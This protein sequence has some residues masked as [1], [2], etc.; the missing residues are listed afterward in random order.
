M[1]SDRTPGPDRTGPLADVPLVDHHCHGVVRRDLDTDDLVGLLT[2]SGRQVPGAPSVLDSRIGL[3]LRRWCP[4]ILDLPVHAPIEDYVA[5]RVEL[6]HREVTARMLRAC[7]ATTFCVDTGFVPEPLLSPDE[8]AATVG[9][10]AGEVVRLET[11]AE[12]AVL[13]GTDAAGFTDALRSL[14]WSR[15]AAAVATKSIA[16]YRV[17]LDLDPARPG[18]AEVVAAAGRWLRTLETDD[19][20][21]RCADPVLSRFL[22]W[23]AVERG[24]PI[25]V[26][27]GLGDAD[28]DL[29]RCDPL[30]L[31]PLLR[32]TGPAGVAVMLL[33]NYPFQRHAGYLAQVFPHVH[34][35]VGL[36]LHNVGAAAP[37]V[38][39]ELLELAPFGKVLYSSD[40]FGLPE[41]YL[42][43]AVAF[44]RSL[45]GL[46][47]DGVSAGEWTAA[48][49]DRIGA[50]LAHGNARRVY[51]LGPA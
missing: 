30:L 37:R 43:G 50:L 5:R 16:A 34:A 14:L 19:A 31:T 21:V 6:G 44:R 20:E 22:W 48:D 49:A 47:V 2:E 4:P 51:G 40:A 27:V 17:G 8:L 3:S 42:L 32:A 13:G 33:H 25:Q 12:E 38:L 11:L 10:R 15:T 26:H 46:L 7:G 39:A 28:V 36:A 45:G 9:G 41:L 18:P 35:D 29:H 1:S 23:E 24:L